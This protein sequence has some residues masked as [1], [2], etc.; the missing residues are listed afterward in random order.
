MNETWLLKWPGDRAVLRRHRRTVRAEVEF[1]HRV[2][3]RARSGGVPCPAV[4]PAL[5][6]GSLVEEDGRFYSL[7]TWA[8]G[9][10]VLRGHLDA[11]HAESMG[12]MLA[13]VHVTFADV[14]GGLEAHDSMV[15]LEDTLRRVDELTGI[16]RDRPDRSRVSWVIEDLTS[17][18]RWLRTERP[19]PP[20]QTRA[21][22][23]VI[24][25]D[26]Q[27]TNLF[28]EGNEVSCVI[29]WDKARREVPAREII[30]A[31]DY[32]LG[33][34][35]QLCRHFL[36]GYRA[37]TPVAPEGL[38][39]AAKWFAYQ[40]AAHGLWPIEQVLLYNNGRVEKRVDHKAFEPF[41]QRWA[42]AALS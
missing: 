19:S 22:S 34:E 29:D 36:N 31:M 11:Q 32:S 41:S 39:E 40:E 1:E 5:R 4:V 8:P 2:L 30:R 14:P 26:Y 25:G 24:H 38:E 20:Q 18:A 7:Y 3:G 28:F 37:I 16:A 9:S 42:A 35:P 15:P 6:G 23:Q 10:Q 17:R 33:M 21:A 13:R 27:E 12:S